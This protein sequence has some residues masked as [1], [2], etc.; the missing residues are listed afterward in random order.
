MKTHTRS[1]YHTVTTED[2][3]IRVSVGISQKKKKTTLYGHTAK[4]HEI[5][6]NLYLFGGGGGNAFEHVDTANKSNDSRCCN[7]DVLF[8]LGVPSLNQVAMNDVQPN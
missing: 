3:S 8:K 4:T 1:R 7:N 6:C 5:L 2:E